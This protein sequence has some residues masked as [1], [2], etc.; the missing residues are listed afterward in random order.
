MRDWYYR[1]NL[2]L[3]SPHFTLH[4]G[5]YLLLIDTQHRY[6]ARLIREHGGDVTAY[7]KDIGSNEYHGDAPLQGNVLRGGVEALRDPAN[8]HRCLFLCYPPPDTSMALE[9]LEAH[10]GRYVAHIGELC[11]DTG[12]PA[13]ETRLWQRYELETTICLP[14]FSNTSYSLMLWRRRDDGAEAP[15]QRDPPAS[16]AVCA[17]P[18]CSI[19]QGLSRCRYC[20]HAASFCCSESCC[21][22]AMPG[23]RAVHLLQFNSFRFR[24]LTHTYTHTH[25]HTSAAIYT[26]TTY[27]TD[28]I[29]CASPSPLI[30]LAVYMYRKCTTL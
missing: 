10:T 13:F 2:P 7:D 9:C 23:H 5:H 30:T 25:I 14:N 21:A 6:W 16:L 1:A 17:N 29:L 22:A 24:P 12:T 18:S 4:L 19:T 26:C 15:A 11:G 8:A 27:A 3:L 28:N 20:R